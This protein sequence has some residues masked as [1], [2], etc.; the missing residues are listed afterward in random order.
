MNSQYPAYVKID[1]VSAYAP[2]SAEICINTV[3]NPTDPIEDITALAWDDS[4]ANI[5]DMVEV[6]ILEWAK[7]FPAEVNFDTG[8]LYTL[9]SVDASPVP[10]GSWVIDLPGTATAGGW[11]K[12]TEE[13]LSFRDTEGQIFKLV[14][15]D[16]DA[17]GGFNRVTNPAS[18]GSAAL[19]AA[20]TAEG[21]AWASR[22]TKR[23][24]VFISR[25]ATLNEKLRRSYRM[26]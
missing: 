25:T 22:N 19:V 26:V 13:T 20:V 7:H 18:I 12:A 14:G 10:R 6:L 11:D 16:V 17:G 21:N 1:Y 2:H 4:S 23:P 8:T 9:A 24:S 15:L 5:V 3:L